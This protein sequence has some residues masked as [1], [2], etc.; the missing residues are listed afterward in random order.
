MYSDSICA[1]CQFSSNNISPCTQTVCV[2]CVSFYK[3]NVWDVACTLTLSLTPALDSVCLAA[4]NIKLYMY[5]CPLQSQGV[6]CISFHKL[7]YESFMTMYSDSVC[8][9]SVFI[10]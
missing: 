7:T 9:V 3:L 8:H 5:T 1:L 6:P 4:V 2:L 10:D